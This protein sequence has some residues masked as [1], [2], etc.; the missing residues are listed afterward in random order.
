M[1]FLEKMNSYKKAIDYYFNDES[2]DFKLDKA[3]SLF[4]KA[5]NE[6]NPQANYDLACLYMDNYN[7]QIDEYKEALKCMKAA[8]NCGVTAAIKEL[9]YMYEKVGDIYKNKG[10]Y[11]DAIK[12]YLNKDNKSSVKNKILFCI[13]SIDIKYDSYLDKEKESVIVFLIDFADRFDEEIKKQLYCVV[14]K[15]FN[16][17][18][19]MK[20]NN[21]ESIEDFKEFRGFINKYDYITSKLELFD[22][23]YIKYGLFLLEHLESIEQV[24]NVLEIINQITMHLDEKQFII[25]KINKWEA[26]NMI[27]CGYNAN[28]LKCIV[29]CFKNTNLINY[30]ENEYDSIINFIRVLIKENENEYAKQLSQYFFEKT[31]HRIS[32]E[33]LYEKSVEKEEFINNLNKFRSTGDYEAGLLVANAYYIGKGV[34][35]NIDLAKKLFAK[36]LFLKKDIRPLECL[37]SIFKSSESLYDY[38]FQNEENNNFDSDNTKITDIIFKTYFDNQEFLS[39]TNETK[40]TDLSTLFPKDYMKKCKNSNCNNCSIWWEYDLKC[41]N[42]VYKDKYYNDYTKIND[43]ILSTL[44]TYNK[45]LLGKKE[46]TIV[47]VGCG[48]LYELKS[49]NDIAK[50]KKIKIN[51]IVLDSHIW[52][53]NSFEDI[54]GKIYLNKIRVKD[55]DF[56]KELK[57]VA[58][59]FVDVIYYSR[60]LDHYKFKGEE[61]SERLDS[62]LNDNQ[63]TIISQAVNGSSKLCKTQSKGDPIDFENELRTY[64]NLNWKN[65]RGIRISKESIYEDICHYYPEINYFAYF[66]KERKK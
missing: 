26:M 3:I 30:S 17:I 7:G 15:R 5:I 16:Q 60:C 25:Q 36:L 29:D 54:A 32:F 20:L 41:S 38:L 51:V 42:I 1:R 4:K 47:L 46:I 59:K 35:K 9:P 56:Y 27:G 21:C 24:N 50:E 61:I 28:K 58:Y 65:Y 6:G 53:V 33:E 12:L 43:V 44:F 23:F 37:Y 2:S 62:I 8:A 45:E 66:L 13:K 63:I 49:L 19:F 55:C 57:N 39:I 22:D 31:N 52:S 14:Y 48:N 34:E 18:F 40:D 11:V 64:F 10:M